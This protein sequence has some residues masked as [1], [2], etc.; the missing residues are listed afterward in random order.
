[1]FCYKKGNEKLCELHN[2]NENSILPNAFLPNTRFNKKHHVVKKLF[3][4]F[5]YSLPLYCLAQ[6]IKSAAIY[7]ESDAH[8]LSKTAINTLDSLVKLG[9]QSVSLSGHCDITASHSYNDVLSQK[10][11][12]ATRQQL[13]AMGIGEH[14]ILAEHAFGKRNLINA[15][16]TDA[17]K[18]LNRRVMISY[19][20][21]PPTIIKETT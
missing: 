2:R 16:R 15:N 19:L 12:Q 6:E 20:T 1:L 5:T 3:F 21:M 9:L 13:L 18:A 4:L 11:V 17:E 14:I 7:F 10:R 8:T